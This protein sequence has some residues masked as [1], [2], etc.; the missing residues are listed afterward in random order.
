MRTTSTSRIFDIAK[1]LQGNRTLKHLDT[2]LYT[3]SRDENALC[4]TST[5]NSTFTSNHVLEGL[6]RMGRTKAPPCIENYL[7]LNS[8][9]GKKCEVAAAKIITCHDHLDMSP[10]FPWRLTLFPDVIDWFERAAKVDS[11]A[12]SQNE[13]AGLRVPIRQGR[14]SSFPVRYHRVQ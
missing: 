10:F 6:G 8:T 13:E 2:S 11:E 4:N 5:I 12:D 7:R 3:D 9:S 14:S 1:A